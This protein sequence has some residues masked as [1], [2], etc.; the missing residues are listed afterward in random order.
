MPTLLG[1]EVKPII[2]EDSGLE[3]MKDI[4]FVP[5]MFMG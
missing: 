4:A 3:K 1:Q 5:K 2:K